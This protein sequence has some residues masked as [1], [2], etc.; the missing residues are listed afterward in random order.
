MLAEARQDEEEEV[1]AEGQSTPILE[2]PRQ[3]EPDKEVN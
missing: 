2:I 3:D 1:T